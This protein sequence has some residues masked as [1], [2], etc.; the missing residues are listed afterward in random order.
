MRRPLGPTPMVRTVR[1]RLSDEDLEMLKEISGDRTYSETIR[2]LI[3]TSYRRKSR[4]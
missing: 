3:L 4:K 1:F 2:A